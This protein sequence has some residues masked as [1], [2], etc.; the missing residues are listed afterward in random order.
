METNID[1]VSQGKQKEM[2]EGRTTTK[3]LKEVHVA[4]KIGQHLSSSTQ[5]TGAA[6]DVRDSADYRT[7]SI[8]NTSAAQGIRDSA[9]DLTKTQMTSKQ[10]ADYA[11]SECIADWVTPKDHSNPANTYTAENK[12]GF[13]FLHMCGMSTEQEPYAKSNITQNTGAAHMTTIASE[14]CEKVQTKSTDWHITTNASDA[15][16]EL[17]T[18]STDIHV[19]SKK[20]DCVTLIEPITKCHSGQKPK[21][22]GNE[23]LDLIELCTILT[24]NTHTH[25]A[26]LHRAQS[27]DTLSFLDLCGV[28]TEQTCKKQKATQH[29]GAARMNTGV[30]NDCRNVQTKSTNL[31]ISEEKTCYK[32]RIEPTTPGNSQRTPTTESNEQL[33]FLDLCQVLS[34]N[35]GHTHDKMTCSSDMT[36]ETLCGTQEGTKLKKMRN[37]KV[38]RTQRPNVH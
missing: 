18:N 4:E 37:R 25:T 30:S 9:D 10:N 17:Q 33:N 19:S 31:R 8:Q 23:Q 15:C 2:T 1:E 20:R 29:T 27:K 34:T 5:N 28:S 35:I 13:N 14:D 16:E 21:T 3:Y 7:S 24:P 11:K 32:K 38:I 26:N 22:Q 6:Q 12:N 36:Y